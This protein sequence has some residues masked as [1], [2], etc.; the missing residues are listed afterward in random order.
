MELPAGYKVDAFQN[1]PLDCYS[2]APGIPE[3]HIARR[4]NVRTLGFA[5]DVTGDGPRV[6]VV[7]G[8]FYATHQGDYTTAASTQRSGA[9]AST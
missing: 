7:R 6:F 4:N 8:M 2:A 5:W 9:S 3:R 1:S